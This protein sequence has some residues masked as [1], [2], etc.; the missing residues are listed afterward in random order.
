MFCGIPIHLQCTVSVPVAVIDPT[1]LSAS[2]IYSPSSCRVTPSRRRLRSSRMWTRSVTGK[3]GGANKKQ[4][5]KERVRLSQEC[6]A[7]DIQ[8]SVKFPHL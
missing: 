2:Q 5:V 4:T 6:G 8:K 1:A 3:S 7:L